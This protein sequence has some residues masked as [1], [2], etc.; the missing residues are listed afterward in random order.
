MNDLTEMQ[1]LFIKHYVNN[2][3]SASKA[4]I[5]AG[6]SEDFAKHQSSKLANH[7]VVRERI[8]HLLERTVKI[9]LDDKIDYLLKMLDDIIPKDGSEPK[10]NLYNTAIKIVS[11]LNRMM[12]DYAPEKRLSVTVDATQKRLE[13]ARKQY[14]EY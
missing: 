8:N 11:E 5:S 2:G 6:Y 1:Y 9:T 4:A 7:P 14:D 13:E 10:R 3:F 12:G